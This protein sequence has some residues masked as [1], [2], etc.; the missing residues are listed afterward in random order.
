TPPAAGAA[1]PALT[2]R[3]GACCLPQP[4]AAQKT[5]TASSDAPP[6]RVRSGTARRIEASDS[7]LELRDRVR[8]VLAAPLERGQLVRGELEL[9]DLLDPL[10]AQ[11]HRHADEQ[12]A[13]PVLALE[14]HP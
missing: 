2:A 4:I 6:R 13:H 12:V 10:A 3:G 9:D 5:T 11:H 8:H 7:D 1:T 14:Q